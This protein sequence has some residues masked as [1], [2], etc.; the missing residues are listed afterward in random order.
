MVT[1]FWF[2]FFYFSRSLFYIHT[3]NCPK[4]NS[5]RLL[6]KRPQLH[7]RG[8]PH[9]PKSRVR[10]LTNSNARFVGITSPTSSFYPV[11]T[12]QFADIA[13]IMSKPVPFV[14]APSFIDS[15]V[16]SR[17]S[18]AVC[19]TCSLP[20]HHKKRRECVE[21]R[22]TDWCQ[23]ETH[24]SQCPF[25]E[26]SEPTNWDPIVRSNLK[27]CFCCGTNAL[28][29]T[30]IDGLSYC[31]S[32]RIKVDT[33]L[34][35]NSKINTMVQNQHPLC[36]ECKTP[37]TF[38]A[39][40]SFSPSVPRSSVST[41]WD[42]NQ[43]VYYYRRQNLTESE[44]VD[45]IGGVLCI[46]CEDNKFD[47]GG[48]SFCCFRCK[49][50]FRSNKLKKRWKEEDLCINCYYSSDIQKEISQKYDVMRSV[51]ILSGGC[52]FPDCPF[53]D[54]KSDFCQF[55]HK[56]MFNYS[57]YDRISS[58][59]ISVQLGAPQSF[60]SREMKRCTP[61]C[62]DAHS[63]ITL[64]EKEMGYH[65]AKGCYTTSSRKY[66]N[67]YGPVLEIVKSQLHEH[68][69]TYFQPALERATKSFLKIREEIECDMCHKPFTKASLKQ[70]HKTRGK[71]ADCG[72]TF[73]CF[74]S[75][76]RPCCFVL[77]SANINWR[78][79]LPLYIDRELIESPDEGRI[80]SIVSR[81]TGFGVV[82]KK[83]STMKQSNESLMISDKWEEWF[84]L[85]YDRWFQEIQDWVNCRQMVLLCHRSVV[86][87]SDQSI[88]GNSL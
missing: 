83:L 73:C 39:V 86:S 57:M 58:P 6:F 43:D 47:G 22:D 23:L 28:Q 48:G 36:V 13:N 29:M 80:R 21:C 32:C 24:A 42:V 72:L 69:A 17:R 40:Q 12:R 74:K 15:Y 66:G 87:S 71:C 33:E 54:N 63:L 9:Q 70:H 85:N 68:Y 56:N 26:L 76:H 1:I 30:S 37:N 50:T 60:I 78:K 84:Y 46:T 52:K 7:L 14:E 27:E 64:V 59:G 38:Q 45:A 4:M 51:I 20:A 10:R 35:Q 3:P 82:M 2:F 18:D 55:D 8:T 62:H 81:I 44:V 16:S 34:F 5:Q 77:P 11:C 61:V 79:V 88:E 53:C 65:K 19:L 25:D 75:K 49:S 31:N 67:E 41:N